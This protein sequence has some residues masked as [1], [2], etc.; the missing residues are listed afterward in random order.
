MRLLGRTPGPAMGVLAAATLFVAV[1]CGGEEREGTTVSGPS[2]AETSYLDDPC[3]R[4]SGARRKRF[5]VTD[6]GFRPRKTAVRNGVPVTFINCGTKPH[7]V[8]KAAGRGD[9]L[10]S[11]TLQPREKFEVTLTELGTITFVD[12]EN[13][14]AKMTLKV[15]GQPMP[16]KP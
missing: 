13:P 11:G 4:P 1:G 12:R 5:H 3:S 9:D 10:S 15:S 16:N 2:D 6:D 14:G 8:T 7:T